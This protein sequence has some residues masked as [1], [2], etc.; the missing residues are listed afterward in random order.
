MVK[1]TRP[2]WVEIQAFLTEQRRCSPVQPRCDRHYRPY[3][4]GVHTDRLHVR[5]FLAILALAALAGCGSRDETRFD[6][7]PGPLRTVDF[8]VAARD[9]RPPLSEDEW[10]SVD[11]MHDRYLLDFDR[12]RQ[13][14]LAPLARE[15]RDAG[16]DRIAQDAAAM[17]RLS[18]RSTAAVARI[19]ALD[20][21]IAFDLAE[22]FPARNAFAERVAQRRAIDRSA[23][24]IE[25]VSR[26]GDDLE[27]TILDLERALGVAGVDAAVRAAAEP[28][29]AA[30]RRDLARAAKALADEYLAYPAALLAECESASVGDQRM[31]EL[32]ARA[33]ESDDAK[34]ELQ[35]ANDERAAADRRADIGRAR[36]YAALD[37]VNRRGLEAICAALP[38][39]DADRLRAADERLRTSE[40]GWMEGSRLGLQVLALHP[41]VREGRAPR[42][43]RAM[44][45][46]REAVGEVTRARIESGRAAFAARA[47]G[48]E[49]PSPDGQQ[50]QARGQRFNVALEAIA[51]A[52]KSELPDDTPQVLG[53]L[54]QLTP[55]QAID[56]LAPIIGQAN[57][58]R[59]IRRSSRT[60]FRS[61]RE[62]AEP[63]WQSNLSIAEQLLLAPGMDHAAYRRAAR[64][65]GARDDDPLVEQIW[66][67]H[68][69]RMDALEVQQR[70]QLRALEKLSIAAAE[71]AREDPAAFER[72]LAEYLSAL[73]SAD[74]ERREADEATFQEIAV[75]IGIAPDDARFV[76]ARSVSAARRASLPWRRFRQPWLLGP[77]WESDADPLSM[78][79]AVDDDVRRTSAIVAVAGHADRL[80][81]SADAARRAGLEALRDL[82]L[83]GTRAQRDGRRADSPE[84]LR[85][86][87]DVRAAL[88]RVRSAAA[89]RR[90]VQRAA[91]DA[92]TAINPELGNEFMHAWVESTLPEFFADGTAR[93]TAE[94]FAA[95]GIPDDAGDA[96][97]AILRGTVDRWRLVD[98]D[99]V[100]K[101][102]EWQ[103]SARDQPAAGS[104]ADLVRLANCDPALA[105]MRTLRDE[106]S[107]RLLRTA[108]TATGLPPDARLAGE[109]AAGAL[110]RAVRWSAP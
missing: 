17:A 103:D 11:A 57:A 5:L 91:I 45:E 10:A 66:E 99:L 29:V 50:E 92:V 53:M 79:L 68:R 67:R 46:F 35:R 86:D 21:R 36:A 102:S 13:E 101:L 39:P 9:E 49:P 75:A 4:P 58:E 65:L 3:T 77:L 104:V 70:E 7:M 31:A 80:R 69:A 48:E 25:G 110:P 14:V 40:D 59:L 84:D 41:A 109:E 64:A 47:A 82:L 32:Q 30:Y 15:V 81:A 56:R 95:A 90:A 73:L 94:D 37:D 71:R 89:E 78:A 76:L 61:P 100:R 52:A 98:D 97:R 42:T 19:Q 93:R 28:A 6:A 51:E 18:K 74:G 85:E 83:T 34:Q 108:A 27:P 38:A 62:N 43:E 33:G 88:Q 20:D 54:G 44:A 63:E 107:W 24:I 87:P 1:E 22:A 55:A 23:R 96:A 60:L 16:P 106:S 72:S 105:A 26:S 8:A 12:L 2:D